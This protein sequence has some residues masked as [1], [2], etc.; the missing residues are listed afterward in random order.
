MINSNNYAFH[1]A[2]VVIIGGGIIG[3]AIAYYLSQQ[4]VGRVLLIE[5]RQLAEANTS[6][7]AALLTRARAKTCLMPLV[8]ETYQVKVFSLRRAVRARALPL[9]AAS[10][11]C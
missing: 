3:C 5:R 1:S 2:D 10:A 6:R 8:R 9:R 4:A 11:W 7:A